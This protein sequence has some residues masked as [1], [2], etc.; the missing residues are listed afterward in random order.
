MRFI[1]SLLILFM[2]SN[3]VFGE[4]L[5][6]CPNTP[7]IWELAMLPKTYPTN[8]LSRK[9]GSSEFA[10]GK[11]IKIEGKVVDS[12]CTPVADARVKIWQ[13]NT[14]GVYE[15]L[16]GDEHLKYKN[17]TGSG[18][19]STDNLGNYVFY[20]IYPG[21]ANQRPPHIFFQVEHQNFKLFRTEMFFPAKKVIK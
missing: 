8:E 20:S 12:N 13:A 6:E 7:E 11:Y 4:N 17:F 3:T 14:N 15:F 9:I 19:T 2:F 5:I 21:S 18:T 10:N 1:I 16:K